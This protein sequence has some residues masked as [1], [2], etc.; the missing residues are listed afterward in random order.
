MTTVNDILTNAFLEAGIIA[1]GEPLAARDSNFGLSKFNRLQDT[2]NAQK[3]YIYSYNFAQYN[4]IAG[5]NPQAIGKGFNITQASLTSNVATFQGVPSYPLPNVGD[6]VTTVN[7]TLDPALNVTAQAIQSISLDGTII[8][9]NITNANISA[10]N[11]SGAMIPATQPASSAPDYVIPTTR[12][13]KIVNANIILNNVPEPVRVPMRIVDADWWANQRVPTI[14]TT[15]PT[16]LYYQ[17]NFPNGSLF[18]W[19][20]PS[21]VYPVELET[22]TNLSEL[23]LFD[24]FQLPQG[25]EDAITYTLAETLCP[26]YGRPMDPTLAALGQKARAMIQGNNSEAP[27]I[28]TSDLGMPGS[29]ADQRGRADF[30][31]LTGNL[32]G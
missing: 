2:W 22:W 17:P 23:G 11:T 18:F 20:V 9:I 1:A 8:T 14:Q 28:S 31:W 24:T 13:T 19:P 30:N 7:V 25:Y 26:S 12:P 32:A 27:H 21:I 4:M 29:A 16:H 10:A 6:L 15:L 3:L 5:K